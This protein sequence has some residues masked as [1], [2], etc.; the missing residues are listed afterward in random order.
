MPSVF[1]FTW[2]LHIKRFLPAELCLINVTPDGQATDWANNLCDAV[3]EIN[4]EVLF[5]PDYDGTTGGDNTGINILILAAD[6]G[7]WLDVCDANGCE[8]E[9][10]PVA[11]AAGHYG[12]G[13]WSGV[14]LI[15]ESDGRLR[16][17][18]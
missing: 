16:W 3:R 12:D 6:L 7:F 1:T 8:A 17:D 13:G 4:P 9:K 15:E 2:S 18:E 11:V 5:A 10:S 14:D